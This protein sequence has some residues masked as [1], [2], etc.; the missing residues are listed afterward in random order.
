MNLLNLIKVYVKGAGVY[1]SFL[2]RKFSR[3]GMSYTE[4][5]RMLKEREKYKESH[6]IVEYY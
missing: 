3:V 4:Y 2:N 1:D 6:N 5:E